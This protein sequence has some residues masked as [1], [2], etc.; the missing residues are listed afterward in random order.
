M[1]ISILV[2]LVIFSFSA[3]AKDKTPAKKESTKVAKAAATATAAPCDSKEDL[4]K[5][6][7]EKKKAEAEAGKPKAFSLKGGD[8][9]CSVK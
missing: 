7:E 9:G 5:K 6:L 4:L 1:K 8:T 3:C 2:M